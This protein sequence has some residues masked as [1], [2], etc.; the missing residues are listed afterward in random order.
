LVLFNIFDTFMAFK[1]RFK[2]RKHINNSHIYITSKHFFKLKI[3]KNTL[4]HV[5]KQLNVERE[6]E[7]IYILKNKS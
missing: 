1:L 4:K 2:I 5:N 7:H 6:R 3:K